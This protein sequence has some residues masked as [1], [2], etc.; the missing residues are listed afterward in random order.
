MPALRDPDWKLPSQESENYDAEMD[1]DP[2]FDET[3]AS[4]ERGHLT[5]PPTLTLTA[6]L[7]LTPPLAYP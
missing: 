5:L 2:K 4:Q 1:V 7:T 6:T 3:T